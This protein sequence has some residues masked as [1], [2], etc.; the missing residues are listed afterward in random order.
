VRSLSGKPKLHW[1]LKFSV[2]HEYPPFG[3]ILCDAYIHIYAWPFPSSCTVCNKSSQ[4]GFDWN[5]A[6]SRIDVCFLSRFAYAMFY[7]VLLIDS[8]YFKSLVLWYR[9]KSLNPV[10]YSSSEILFVYLLYLSKLYLPF[11]TVSFPTKVPHLL[12][13]NTLPFNSPAQCLGDI[14]CKLF[15][16]RT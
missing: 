1:A 14:Y 12:N 11:S 4:D 6:C 13:S 15:T 9:I 8:I 16:F 7:R 10:L 3:G 5:S 2:H